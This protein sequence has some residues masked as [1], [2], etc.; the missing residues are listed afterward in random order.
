[1]ELDDAHASS[2]GACSPT[3]MDTNVD[4]CDEPAAFNSHAD[5]SIDSSTVTED[6][7]CSAGANGDAAPMQVVNTDDQ[8]P[9]NAAAVNNSQGDKGSGKTHHATKDSSD[10]AGTDIQASDGKTESTTSSSLG[11]DFDEYFTSG[12]FTPAPDRKMAS[13][14]F[15]TFGPSGF[16]GALGKLLRMDTATLS[17]ESDHDVD[18]TRLRALYHL[19][20]KVPCGDVFCA[21]I[22]R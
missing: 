6:A 14:I 12:I 3:P 5:P 18:L 1:M 20:C 2:D 15:E 16:E 13:F 19:L 22:R 9:D 17:L 7:G 8:V 11:P 4:R 10:I 21:V